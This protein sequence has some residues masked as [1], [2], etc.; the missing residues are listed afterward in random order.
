NLLLWS[1]SQKGML[2]PVLRDEDMADLAAEAVYSV[3]KNEIIELDIPAGLRVQTDRNMLLTCLRNLLDNA[4]KASPEGGKVVLSAEGRRITI[5]DQGPGMK[6]GATGWGHG[7]GLV[8]TREL[9]EKMGA[10]MTAL[11]RPEGG[12]EITITL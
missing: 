4:V 8:I 6:E 7:L 9:L 11:N 12:L 3:R 5:T 1:L 2:E 10:K